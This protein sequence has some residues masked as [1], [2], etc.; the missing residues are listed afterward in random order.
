MFYG[1]LVRVGETFK[2][3]LQI[4]GCELYKN[5][6]GG[7]V[8]PGLT[9]GAIALPRPPSRYKEGERGEGKERVGNRGGRKGR[10]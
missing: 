10:A 7:R 1:R 4:W 8:P 3:D 5:A 2:R 9:G 6:F